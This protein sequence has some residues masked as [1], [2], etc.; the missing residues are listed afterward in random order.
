MGEMLGGDQEASDHDII[1]GEQVRLAEVEPRLSRKDK[2]LAAV[3]FINAVVEL[4]LGGG[5][6][7]IRQRMWAASDN[8][9][10]LRQTFPKRCLIRRLMPFKVMRVSHS[11]GL[12]NDWNRVW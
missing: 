8:L 3:V 2:S 7:H 5:Y 4:N 10:H 1:V 6:S 11:R 9:S 12:L